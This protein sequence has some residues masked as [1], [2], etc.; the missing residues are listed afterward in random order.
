MTNNF[1]TPEANK[2]AEILSNR[3]IPQVVVEAHYAFSQAALGDDWL[4]TEV[5]WKT[6]ETTLENWIRELERI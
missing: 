4:A 6:Y 2:V 3:F 1:T 5:A